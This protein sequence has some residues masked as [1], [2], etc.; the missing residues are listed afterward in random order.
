MIID[1]ASSRHKYNGTWSLIAPSSQTTFHSHFLR[2]IR[3]AMSAIN[4]ANITLT[5]TLSLSFIQ[6][7]RFQQSLRVIQLLVS[8]QT[9]FSVGSIR[10]T[11]FFSLRKALPIST[12]TSSLIGPS[13]D[14]LIIVVSTLKLFVYFEF[15]LIFSNY[16]MSLA[17]RSTRGCLILYT[18]GWVTG[19]SF[20]IRVGFPWSRQILHHVFWEDHVDRD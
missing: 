11:T 5:L 19:M 14:Q 10:K 13:R 15:V 7:H 17:S 12:S 18:S 9:N 2:S 6:S 4:T 20:E 8:S 1:D 16:S 3:K